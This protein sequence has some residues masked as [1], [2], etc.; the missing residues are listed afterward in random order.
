MFFR[1]RGA[2]TR[3]E[4]IAVGRAIREL[5]RLRRLYGPGRWRK[6][7][8]Q[9]LVELPDGSVLPAEIH[10]Y[11]ATGIGRVEYKIKRLL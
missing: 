2:V 7:K 6:R 9:A 5:P 10:W 8:G 4:T 11:E 1:I 3:V